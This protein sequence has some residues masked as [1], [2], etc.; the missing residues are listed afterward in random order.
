MS[1]ID[2]PKNIFKLPTQTQSAF[3]FMLFNWIECNNY[4][5][6]IGP[7]RRKV[8]ANYYSRS[9]DPDSRAVQNIFRGL[10]KSGLLVKCKKSDLIC[11]SN[12]TYEATYRIPFI[13]SQQKMNDSFIKL[14]KEII[15]LK[16]E[17]HKRTRSYLISKA[18]ETL[19]K[20]KI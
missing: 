4:S 6:T 16:S 20:L 7:E 17:L 19:W 18:K 12:K 5:I 8:L 3:W 1:S 14:H 15:Q 13:V 10:T 11:K 2:F 9:N